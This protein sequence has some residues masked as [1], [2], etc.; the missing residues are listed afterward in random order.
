[1]RDALPPSESMLNTTHAPHLTPRPSLFPAQIQDLVDEGRQVLLVSSG[2]VGLGRLRLG[3]SK[4]VVK[5]PANVMDRQACAAAGQEVRQCA[6]APRWP[7]PVHFPCS[8]LCCVC[9]CF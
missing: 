1:M 2:A 6:R 4:E 9:D 5:N 8:A 3:L 7:A